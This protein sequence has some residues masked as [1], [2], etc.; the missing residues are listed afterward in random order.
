ME[1]FCQL[2]KEKA[3]FVEEFWELGKYFFT[4]PESYDAD[5]IKKRWK[6]NVPQ[7]IAQV[8]E[9]L[10][11]LSNF[12][13]QEIELTLKSTA[14]RMGINP[15]S[16]MQVFRVCLS[17]VGGGPVLFEMVELL[18]KDETVRRLETALNKIH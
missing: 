7:F 13:A 8:K 4:P 16:V 5:V 6:D 10:K 11:N 18:G 9:D 15:G 14:E 3:H 1:K 12:K 17:G 2:I